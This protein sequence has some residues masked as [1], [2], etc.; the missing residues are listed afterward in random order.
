M[1]VSFCPFVA[2]RFPEQVWSWRTAG[3]LNFCQWIDSLSSAPECRVASLPRLIHSFA[4]S[5]TLGLMD[6][7]YVLRGTKYV[8]LI[9]NYN[10]KKFFNSLHWHLCSHLTFRFVR[11]F[12]TFRAFFFS[13]LNIPS[14]CLPACSQRNGLS[15][16]WSGKS[17]SEPWTQRPMWWSGGWALCPNTSLSE[18][19]PGVPTHWQRDYLRIEMVED[20]QPHLYG[21]KSI[22][23]IAAPR[24]R[25]GAL[26]VL[27]LPSRSESSQ[28]EAEEA[29]WLRG[30]SLRDGNSL[31]SHEAPSSL[32]S[33]G[34]PFL[35][36]GILNGRE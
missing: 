18:L 27:P 24:G 17:G 33:C 5:K 20:T 6:L 15:Y 2:F 16:D 7:V 35:N 34:S 32:P 21:L 28:L 8:F 12:Y 1:N 36:L 30:V 13:G 29:G 26:Q 11:K 25:A 22:S 3:V 10:E 4:Y 23:D 14:F 9:K 19:L 31:L